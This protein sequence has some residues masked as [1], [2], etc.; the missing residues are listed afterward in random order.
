MILE[1]GNESFCYFNNS[2][3]FATCLFHNI[4]LI[5]IFAHSIINVFIEIANISTITLNV[6]IKHIQFMQFSFI[7]IN[8]CVICT[9]YVL[10][11]VSDIDLFS[12]NLNIKNLF[13]VCKEEAKLYLEESP[14]LKKCVEKQ[15]N[16]IEHI[17][18]I[19]YIFYI[20]IC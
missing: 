6:S 1:H 14:Q 16:H 5:N 4:C 9:R 15:F 3:L 7:K 17:K 12:F 8:V 13:A 2:S 11:I 20:S 18:Y 19:L 10:N